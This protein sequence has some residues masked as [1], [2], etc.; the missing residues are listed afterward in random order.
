MV[1]LTLSREDVVSL[2]CVSRV[3]GTENLPLL[4]LPLRLVDR[5]NV[6]LNLH[7]DAA[8]LFN[9]AATAVKTLSR[10]DGKG[11]YQFISIS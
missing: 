9:G 8:V 4:A 2:K 6:V 3:V 10:L 5:I 11:P 1:S 7:D